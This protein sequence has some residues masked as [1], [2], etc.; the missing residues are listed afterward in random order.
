MTQDLYNLEDEVSLDEHVPEYPGERRD[1]K[2]AEC[3]ALMGLRK[4]K[5][6]PFY[7][8]S[9][10][11]ETGCKGSH[12]AHPSGAPFGTP[13]DKTGKQARIEAHRVFDEVWKRRLI[14]SGKSRNANRHMAYSWMRK[15]MDLTHNTAHIGNFDKPQCEKLMLL[16]HRDYPQLRTRWSRLMYDDAL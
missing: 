2:C 12:G 14:N 9:N 3:G 1:L 5:H 6:G 10:F 15:A 13:A 7:G 4:S 8:C 16:V 11:R